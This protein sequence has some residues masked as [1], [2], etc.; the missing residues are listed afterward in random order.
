MGRTV[1]YNAFISY[2]HA[3]D[4]R[5]AP[6]LQQ[7]LHRLARPWYRLRAL[8]AFR[9]KTSLAA[10]PALW[11]TIVQ[12][13]AASEW[14]VF[15]A[16]PRAAQSHWVQQEIAWWLDNRPAD[17]LLIV[18]TDGE[19]AWDDAAKDF[20]WQSTSAVP[21]LLKGRFAGE[22]LYVDLRWARSENDLSLRHSRFRAAI[23]DI[24]AP[25]HGRAKDELDGDD[26]RQHRR[27]R[28]L[29][30]SAGIGLGVLAVAASASAVIAV[31]QRNEA[32]LRRQVAT[33]R[34]LSAQVLNR[35]A[36]DR[37]DTALLLALE[38][39]NAVAASPGVAEAHGFDARSTLLLALDHGAAP[40][41]AYLHGGGLMALSAD[42][43]T[44]ATASAGEGRAGAGR[45][46]AITLWDTASRRPVGRVLSGHGDA[47]LGLAFSPDGRSLVSS[48]RSDK[49][50]IVWDLSAGK[51]AG[52]AIAA[53][54][55]STVALAISPDG[56]LM[57]TGGG[58]Q[59]VQLWN[60]AD[61]TPLGPPLRGH[62][63]NVVSLAFSPDGSLLATGS[64]DG[65]VIV[66]DM[67]TRRPRL[68]PLS[69]S[70]VQIE[71][72]AFSPD[73]RLVAA[74][75]GGGA[76]LWDVAT[77]QPRQPALDHEGGVRSVAFSPDGRLLATG[78]GAGTLIL[79]RVDKGERMR[80]ALRGHQRWIESIVFTPDGKGLASSS[81]DTTILWDLASVRRLAAVQ[82]GPTGWIDALAFDGRG[83]MLAAGGCRDGADAARP[84]ETAR[85]AHWT[86]CRQA[87]IWLVRASAGQAGTGEI[88]HA[89]PAGFPGTPKSL[90][91]LDGPSEGGQTL[92]AAGCATIETGDCR[93]VAVETWRADGSRAGRSVITTDGR[94]SAMAVS[95]QGRL[96]ATAAGDVR[97][98]DVASGR[99]VGSPLVGHD[100]VVN[101][102][103]F[104][105]DGRTLASSTLDDVILWD[106][107]SGRP[108]GRPQPGGGVAFRGDGVVVAVS[109]PPASATPRRIVLLD[110]ASNRQVGEITIGDDE[111]VI[112]MAFSPDGRTL[113]VSAG[114][115]GGGGTFTVWDIAR[116]ERRGPPMPWP[117]GRSFA[118][119]FD[120]DGKTVATGSETGRLVLWNVDPTSWRDLACRVANR[121]LTY[122]EWTQFIGEE[123]YRRTCAP[124]PADPGLVEAARRRA[125]SGDLDGAIALFE[126][127]REL[128]PALQLDPRR[129]AVKSS[130]E[131][132][133]ANARY[134]AAAG[135]IEAAT[136]TFERARTLDRDL[137]IKPEAEARK[138][139]APAVAAEAARL[140]GQGRIAE[141]L[142]GLERARTYDAALEVPA[143]TWIALCWQGALR[144]QA[145]AVA[146][147]CDR[148][149]AGTAPQGRAMTSRAIARAMLG[150]LDEAMSDIRSFLDWEVHEQTR[151][152]GFERRR[153][154]AEQRSRH[155]QWLAALSAG[156]NPFTP[157]ERKRLLDGETTE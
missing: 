74:G 24:A 59:T 76:W 117:D 132:L 42:G 26:V 93:G 49:A 68:P 77:G 7:G 39:H 44:L 87:G 56:K 70:S 143:A 46:D 53:H 113:A 80:P 153:Q 20:D 137:A 69:M 21:G 25:L 95:P 85:S 110:A 12:A 118:L 10:N 33:S 99:P 47:V 83:G 86:A 51:P 105:P 35:L 52:P 54:G 115:K 119:A 15:L 133:V 145:A 139:A 19:L 144:D 37:V 34:Q 107:A 149:M 64:W 6:A 31:Q 125:R 78:G 57:A 23:L 60:L 81:D 71:S 43:K 141:A 65:S 28:R 157:E 94:L 109:P 122:A 38:A 126:R 127:A 66:W 75:G 98:W 96:V 101:R 111:V 138:L 89:L 123:P 131:E 128:D 146:A 27:T 142:A 135:D 16:S 73:G 108:R 121:N 5:L 120:P 4:D 148:A 72:V 67:A 79:W 97:L 116:A 136:A 1:L 91:F 92:L 55:G 30:W 112:E 114:G 61:R 40:I 50:V 100:R 32:E 134:L 41:D 124:W 104:S 22:P 11:D 3:A 9:D 88:L 62:R 151:R 90:A 140:A 103:A 45:A 58:N 82:Q 8:R 130:V 48:S 13:L 18:L 14:F 102:L 106:V 155:E 63:S 152:M 84:A 147:A 2:S 29:A 129:E 36:V 150:R 17:R 154:L 156:Q